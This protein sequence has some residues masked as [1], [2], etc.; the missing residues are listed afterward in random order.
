MVGREGKGGHWKQD[1]RALRLGGSS[2]KIQNKRSGMHAGN[3]CNVVTSGRAGPRH[4]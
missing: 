2:K 4:A 3:K 1:S